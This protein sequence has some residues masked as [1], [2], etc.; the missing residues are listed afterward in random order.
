MQ[1]ARTYEGISFKELKKLRSQAKILLVTVTDIET[2]ALYEFLK[3]LPDKQ[4]IQKSSSGILTYNVGVLGKYK[5]CHVG[6]N[7][8]SIAIGGSLMTI[9]QAITEWSPKIIVMIGIAFGKDKQK[10]QIGDVLVSRHIISYQNIK[11]TSTGKIEGR[12]SK[13]YCGPKLLDRF[14]SFCSDWRYSVGESAQ[15]S[16]LIGDILS[17]EV[18]IDNE[19]YRNAQLERFPT[20]IGGEMEGIGVANAAAANVTEWIVV[21]SICDFADG[22]KGEDKTR[23]QKIAAGAATSLCEFI[24]NQGHI[25]EEFKIKALAEVALLQ[26]TQEPDI[27]KDVPL[28]EVEIP[29]ILDLTDEGMQAD[30][31][32][33]LTQAFFGQT[34]INRFRIGL[35][36]G[37]I[38]IEETQSANKDAVAAQI[39]IRA[40]QQHLF[41]KLWTM[42]FNEEKE[43]NPFK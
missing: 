24:F 38:K 13:H 21:K 17:G 29:D 16:V 30:D 8:G 43:P 3:P 9:Q 15:S 14:K 25:F 33:K 1:H 32:T 18:L 37:L 7:M 26:D 10:Q 40:Q 42:L 31:T 12:E 35:K 4:L 11:V 28:E 19:E 20:A 6:C 2:E 36:L 34:M 27:N 5:V 23:Y 22:H 41:A 39:L